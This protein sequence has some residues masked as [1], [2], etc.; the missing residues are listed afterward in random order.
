MI[1]YYEPA[2]LGRALA[3]VYCTRGMR[4][5]DVA[6][7][8]L[9]SG[10]PQGSGFNTPFREWLRRPPFELAKSAARGRPPFVLPDRKKVGRWK[11]LTRSPRETTSVSSISFHCPHPLLPTF[12]LGAS[13]IYSQGLEGRLFGSPSV[14]TRERIVSK[15]ALPARNNSRRG[16][17]PSWAFGGISVC[18]VA[19]W[20]RWR[21]M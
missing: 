11:G 21:V 2:E 15:S 18:L 13:S 10:S 8:V 16:R 19:Y 20:G 4:W 1:S 3:I 14:S 7:R 17:Y 6:V 5:V 9:V 12:H